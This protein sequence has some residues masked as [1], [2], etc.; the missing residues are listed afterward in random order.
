MRLKKQMNK[1]LILL[2]TIL[3]IIPTKSFSAVKGLKEIVSEEYE[4]EMILQP[5]DMVTKKGVLVPESN[6]RFYQSQ[7]NRDEILEGALK[8]CIKSTDEFDPK[9][10]FAGGIVLGVLAT[11][12]LFITLKH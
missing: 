9:I 7:V 10:P 2:L 3:L 12:L 6:Y 1:P 4:L 5:G 8:E 11:S